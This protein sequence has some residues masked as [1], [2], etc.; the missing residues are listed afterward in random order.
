MW[1]QSRSSSNCTFLHLDWRQPLAPLPILPPK[2]SADPS[3]SSPVDLS[4][5]DYFLASDVAYEPA[6]T[7]V[8]FVAL[9]TLLLAAAPHAT[10]LVTLERRINFSAA[11]CDEVALDADVFADVS[12]LRCPSRPLSR[13]AQA[14]PSVRHGLRLRRAWQL[15]AGVFRPQGALSSPPPR[16]CLSIPRFS[17]LDVTAVPPFLFQQARCSHPRTQFE[18]WE[19]AHGRPA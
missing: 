17:Q 16:A 7:R 5:V 1:S 11:L 3:D 12:I 6:L 9:R 18:M 10:A 4:R 15:D 8:F 14:C 19:I 13:A 2:N